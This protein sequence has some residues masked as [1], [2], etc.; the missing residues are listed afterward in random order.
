MTGLGEGLEFSLA[1]LPRLS[2]SFVKPISTLFHETV[3]S[4]AA[5]LDTNGLGRIT[6]LR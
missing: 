3:R 6:I 1:G 4:T 5:V 2:L